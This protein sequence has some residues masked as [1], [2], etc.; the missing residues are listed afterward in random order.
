M[1]ESMQ[2]MATSAAMDRRAMDRSCSPPWQKIM[3]PVK[4][5]VKCMIPHTSRQ[6][7][8]NSGRTQPKR[9]SVLA[10][11]CL[12]PCLQQPLQIMRTKPQKWLLIM[13]VVL[14]LLLL[15]ILQP[16]LIQQQLKTLPL[17]T[18]RYY[19][20]K[21]HTISWQLPIHKRRPTCSKRSSRGGK[22]TSA[23]SRPEA[24]RN[25]ASGYRHA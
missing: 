8:R 4:P 11:W 1:T 19:S 7:P 15:I 2:R 18:K 21:H 3:S 22:G 14:I 25:Q 10:R 16:P 9:G 6:P 5:A 12:T 23:A 20:C 17:S 24:L 13:M